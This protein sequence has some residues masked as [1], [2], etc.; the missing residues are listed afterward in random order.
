MTFRNRLLLGMALI[1][2]A[3]IAAIVVAN[4]GLRSTSARFGSFLD[5]IGSLQQSYQEMYSQGLQMGQALRNIVLDPSNPKAFEN[6]EKARKDFAEARDQAGLAAKS[7]N[8]F[9]AALARLSPLV[10]AQAEAQ[11]EVLAVVKSSQI[12]DAKRLI[13]STETPAWRAL[14]KA[15]LNDLEAISKAT[16]SQRHDVASKAEQ[17]ENIMLALSVLA[18][19]VGIASVFS[20]L[21][22]VRREL[23][24]EPGYAR[25]VANAVATGDL[26]QPISLAEGDTSSLLAG[27]AGM[28]AHLRQLV[29]SLAN[30]ASD[31]AQ[32]ANQMAMITGKVASGSEQ[33]QEVASAMVS[34]GQNLSASL[35]QVMGAV[36]EAEQIVQGSSEI[37]G[38]GAALASKAAEETKS[39]AGSVQTTAT[40]I[41]ELGALSAQINSILSVISDIASQTNLLALNAAI[42][43][44]RAGEQGRGFAVVADEVRKLAERTAQ[45]TSEISAMVESIQSGTS[46]AVEAMESGMHQVDDSVQLSNQA[47]D[48]FDRMN[49]S[50]LEVRQV[51]AR[52][53]E[54][55]DVEYQ[56]E[57]AMQHHIEEVRKLIDDSSQAMQEVVVSAEQLRRMSGALSQEVSR[58]K[59]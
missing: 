4:S 51:V 57:G 36:N 2:A 9:D 47:R 13:N 49:A 24:G 39:M 25:K 55:I 48:A 42:E 15:L 44:A 19:V 56:N 11:A 14:K 8:G 16:D 29:S 6:L 59:L 1:M 22:Y 38:S 33:Q 30:H 28:Q 12:E 54:A 3:F 35:H 7:V 32:T 41:R 26:T 58:F 53:T 23:G 10:Q 31:V 5:G 50:S 43:A 52:I 40:H 21:R 20:T 17:A 37:S 45:S 18:I 27:L 46:R 34:N